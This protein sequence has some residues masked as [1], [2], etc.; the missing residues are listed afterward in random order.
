MKRKL[1]GTIIL[2]PGKEK[3]PSYWYQDDGVHGVG[4]CLKDHQPGWVLQGQP[5][6]LEEYLE[7]C[8]KGAGARTDL[9]SCKRKIDEGVH[10][11]TLMEEEDHFA[12]MAVHRKFFAEYQSYAKRRKIYEEPYVEVIYGPTGCNKT[13][14]VYE[15]HDID[16][17]YVWGPTQ[18]SW[19]D[20]YAGQSVVLFDEFRGQIPWG[21]LLQL[22]H[23]YPGLKA[24]VKC[25]MVYWSPKKIYFTS[26]THPNKWYANVAEDAYAQFERRITKLT[27][28]IRGEPLGPVEEPLQI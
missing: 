2:V 17:M 25:G 7:Q 5:P 3:P 10:Y 22:T 14:R 12:T 16:D 27:L 19:F 1:I 11:E 4:Y 9:V 13:R 21:A 24:Q 15:A 26:P 23:G 20:G 18:G 8:P 28:A 6:T